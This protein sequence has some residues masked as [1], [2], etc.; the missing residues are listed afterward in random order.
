M[1]AKRPRRNQGTEDFS[2]MIAG[3]RRFPLGRG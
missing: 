3:A 1:T 2:L